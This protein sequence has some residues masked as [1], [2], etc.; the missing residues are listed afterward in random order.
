M[1]YGVIE[2]QYTVTD[3]QYFVIRQYGR[4]VFRIIE[5]FSGSLDRVQGSLCYTQKLYH[6]KGFESMAKTTDKRLES[7]FT[8]EELALIR[9]QRA[10]YQKSWWAKMSPEERKERKARYALHTAQR[11]AA[12]AQELAGEPV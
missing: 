9:K 1:H 7:L 4:I 2:S 5:C 3:S 12:A 10:E 6:K 11:K 8:P